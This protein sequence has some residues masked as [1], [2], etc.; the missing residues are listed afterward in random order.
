MPRRSI[1]YFSDAGFFFSFQR[2]PS[3]RSFP[4]HTGIWHGHTVHCFLLLNVPFTLWENSITWSCC[5]ITWF[6]G[7]GF[8]SLD[9]LPRARTH[10]SGRR[11]SLHQGGSWK[12]VF[13]PRGKLAQESP[14]P[15]LQ[16]RD[17]SAIIFPPR[18][19]VPT[20]FPGE[21]EISGSLLKHR[22]I[23]RLGDN[24]RTREVVIGR[25]VCQERLC[26]I[27]Y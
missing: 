15:R 4:L 11:H 20:L 10:S 27:L 12:T 1:T 8:A 5:K 3:F 17:A 21:G 23:K 7:A 22:L 13:S 26:K 2:V 9:R 14:P 25:R 19:Q 24:S 18:R 6:S 16:G